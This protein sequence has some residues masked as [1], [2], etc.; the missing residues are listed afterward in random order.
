MEL[1]DAAVTNIELSVTMAN[2]E[3]SL[4]SFL[5]LLNPRP[6]PGTTI[7]PPSASDRG[8]E[9]RD[10]SIMDQARQGGEGGKTGED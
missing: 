2:V 8:L 7:L 9:S 10:L 1:S 6:G 4:G 5:Q 3:R